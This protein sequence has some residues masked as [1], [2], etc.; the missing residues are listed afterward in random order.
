[1]LSLFLARCARHC[2]AVH[3]LWPEGFAF[4]GNGLCVVNATPGYR[5]GLLG[6]LL[7]APWGALLESLRDR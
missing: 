6:Y 2:A 7:G 4:F 3:R 5:R 1:M